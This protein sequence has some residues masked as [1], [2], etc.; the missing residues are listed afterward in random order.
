MLSKPVY[1]K[2]NAQ[3]THEMASAYLYLSMAAYFENENLPG[4]ANWMRV[5]FAEEQEHAL[6][7][8]EYILDRGDKVALQ[9][10]PQPAVDFKSPEDVFKQTLAHEQKVTSLILA[11]YAEAV[12]QNDVAAQIFLQWFINEQ[13][14]EEKN[15]S[16][17]LDVLGKIGSSAGGLYQ[18]DHQLGKRKGD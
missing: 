9:A 11:I 1:E 7:F 4:F 18:L 6:K 15:A 12:A 5:Q 14:E 17:I 16:Q 13:V 8:F 3:I 2:M 10:I